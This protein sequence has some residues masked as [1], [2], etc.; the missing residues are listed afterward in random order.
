MD[1]ELPADDR[2][3]LFL[4]IA[5]LVRAAIARGDLAPGALL[6]PVRALAAQIG[7]HANTTLHAYRALAADGAV[8]SRR[9]LGTFVT[10]R[11]TGDAERRVLA[12]QVAERARRDAFAHGLGADDLAAALER[13]ARRDRPRPRD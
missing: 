12:D 13:A 10:G 6:P 2:R 3:P 8:K 11:P 9:G 1:F 5:D 7:V 4:Q